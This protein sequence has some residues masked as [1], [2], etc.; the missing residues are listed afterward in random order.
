MLLSASLSPDAE[1]GFFNIAGSFGVDKAYRD[2]EAGRWDWTHYN[3]MLLE[4]PSE[5]GKDR[6][7]GGEDVAVCSGGLTRIETTTWDDANPVMIGP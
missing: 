1:N 4:R 3:I 6:D 2:L 5:V 7:T